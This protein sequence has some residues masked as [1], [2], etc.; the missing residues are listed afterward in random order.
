MSFESSQYDVIEGENV[1]VCA[2][3]ELGTSNIGFTLEL[4]GTLMTAEGRN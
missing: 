1:S 2:R 3:I 4:I